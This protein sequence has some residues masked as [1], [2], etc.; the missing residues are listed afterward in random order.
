MATKSKLS[1]RENL[2]EFLYSTKEEAATVLRA[3]SIGNSVLALSLLLFIYGFPLKKADVNF[4]FAILNLVFIVFTLHYF[5]RLLYAFERKQFIK[6]TWLEGLLVFLIVF[7]GFANL[8]LDYKIIRQISR[9]LSLDR[10]RAFYEILVTLYIAILA[11]IELAKNVVSIFNTRVKPTTAFLV[12]FVILILV[13]TGG[14]M[15]PQATVQ[16][17]SMPFIDAFFTATSASCVTG[18][19]V[20]DT[21][22]YFTFKGKILL[23]LVIQIGGLG[24][25]TFATFFAILLNQQMGIVH[26]SVMQEMLNSENLFST[27]G[28]LRNVIRLTLLIELVGAVIIYFTW[29]EQV[30]FKSTQEKVFFSI[31]HS[32]S[33]FC[34]AGF[35]LYSNG[36][37]EAGVKDAYALHLVLIVIIVLGG[38]GFNVLQDFSRR[39]LRERLKMPWKDWQIGTKIAIFMS[40]FLIL[41]GTVVFL[42]LEYNNTLGEL[43]TMEKIITAL[44][45]SVTTRTAG[46]NTVDIG[47]LSVPTLIV[48][49]SFMFIG[50]SPLSTG[51]GIK[52][53]TIWLILASSVANIKGK[54]GVDFGNRS[55]PNEIIAKAN[56]VFIIA[57]LY[58]F[59]SFLLLSIFEKDIPIIQLVFEQ[60]SALGTVGLSTG[61]TGILSTPSKI[62]II[63]SMYLG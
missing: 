6:D 19:I 27:K 46:F 32:V 30:Y 55:I 43:N 47:Q 35:S 25:V 20:V 11:V 51:G 26:Q 63:L 38:I 53:T 3:V 12:S 42:V 4:L 37:Y 56:A 39:R 14:F 60:V 49:L 21:A 16:P 23:L 36:L 7:N 10:P 58:N 13:A 22:T 17:G 18:L 29:G 50:A 44:F 52:T 2:R 41:A 31:F 45:Q 5:L 34:N 1:W 61:I 40:L 57:I 15:L 28:L 24:I 59:T 48:F 8:F 62:V 33:A 9:L 54:K